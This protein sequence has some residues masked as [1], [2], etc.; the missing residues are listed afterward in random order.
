[1]GWIVDEGN[2]VGHGRVD[3]G[4]L[5]DDGLQSRGAGCSHAGQVVGIFSR[6]AELGGDV[7]PCSGA[8]GVG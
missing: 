8:V 3:Q 6:A 7:E 4:V 5:V 2:V 1:M